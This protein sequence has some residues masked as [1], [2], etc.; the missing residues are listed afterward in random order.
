VGRLLPWSV[1]SMARDDHRQAVTPRVQTTAAEFPEDFSFLLNVL[2]EHRVRYKVAYG[3]R[4][5]MKSYAFADAGLIR[6]AQQFERVLC[7]REL[8]ASLKESVHHLLAARIRTL[9]LQSAYTVQEAT[10][11]GP[12]WL[13]G[14]RTEFVFAGL[15]HNIDARIEEAANVSKASWD[16]L[17]PTIRWHDPKTGRKAEVWITYNPKLA[18]DET[19]KRTVI[20]P[21]PDSIVKRTYYY[22]NPWLPDDLRAMAE[23][24]R[25]N[26]PRDYR[27][28]WLGEPV[29][30][31]DGAIFGEQLRAVD[32]EGRILPLPI[33]K[34]HPVDC[35]WDLGYG[36]T[37]AIW[38]MQ[39]L[40]GWFQ[41]IDYDEGNALT[42]ADWSVRLQSK[43]YSYGTMWLPHD[44]VDALLHKRLAA[45]AGKSVEMVLRELGW[46]VRVAPK[47]AVNDR[48]D[49]ARSVFSQC[50]FDQTRCADGLQGLRH[51][52]WAPIASAVEPPERSG[53]VRRPVDT[54]PTPLHNWASHPA[55]AFCTLAVAA[56]HPPKPETAKKPPPRPVSAW[57]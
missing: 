15:R 19:Y 11:L 2:P 53:G 33:S 16:T 21:L 39:A 18:T 14:K 46:K 37:N 40:G 9:G 44:G 4:G 56:K 30:E 12:K 31:V 13:D 6:G 54:R 48:I 29:N 47:L 17:D 36:D 55:D 3:G 34:T 26:N 42:V 25:L 10:I 23:Y 22:E 49:A 45:S 43:G 5:G 35:Y 51:Y 50:R 1:P 20:T 24:A 8:M 28:I 38:F 57:A 27:H 7:G 52:Q 32:N 41:V